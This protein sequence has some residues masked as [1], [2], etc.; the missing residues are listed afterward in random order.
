MFGW[1]DSV[2][3]GRQCFV[4]ATVFG[5]GDNVLL[6]RQ[7]L[8]G[9]TVFGWGDSVWLGIEMAAQEYEHDRK[10]S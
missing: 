4:G 10:A 2:W 9:A 1:G 5:W 8:V 7:C 3:L 6:G